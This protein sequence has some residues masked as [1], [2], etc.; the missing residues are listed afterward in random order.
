MAQR[1]NRFGVYLAVLDPV[2]GSETA[3]TRPCAIVSPDE[4]NRRLRTAILVPLTS[5][6]KHH[7][8]RV[9]VEFGG[10]VGELLTD[11]V[12]SVDKS[13][14]LRQLGTLDRRTSEALAATLVHIFWL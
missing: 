12:R 14:L 9:P 11:Q 1:A 4:M 6:P 10:V 2:R 5:K 3:K 13:R 8:F 7:P